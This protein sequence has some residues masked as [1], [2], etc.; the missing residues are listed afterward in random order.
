MKDMPSKKKDA[1]TNFPRPADA[2]TLQPPDGEMSPAAC[3]LKRAL[4][5]NEKLTET[6]LS[7]SL[8]AAC[9]LLAK[10]LAAQTGTITPG[11]IAALPDFLF[12]LALFA[13]W[14][15]ALPIGPGFTAEEPDDDHVCLGSEVVHR[16]F[17][18]QFVALIQETV[19]VQPFRWE[20]S[21]VIAG[22]KLC[23]SV[24]KR[25]CPGGPS[26]RNLASRR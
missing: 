18:E 3:T 20:S 19:S 5:G 24:M 10:Y 21:A 1:D 16:T 2:R 4:D 22:M 9:A 12:E 13:G 8:N 7:K 17:R 15:P 11:Q 23:G 14:L 26:E 6:T 25:G